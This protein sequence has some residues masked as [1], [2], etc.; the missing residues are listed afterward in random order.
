MKTPHLLLILSATLFAAIALPGIRADDKVKIKDD[1]II[2][3]TPGGKAKIDED[4]NV[5]SAKGPNA[6]EAVSKARQKLS[7][8]E[9]AQYRRDF[10]KGYVIP[11]ERYTYFEPLAATYLERIPERRP[12]VEYRVF[13]GT[14]YA[15]DPSSY[16]II[17]VLGGD[18]LGASA[19]V[20]T[21][22]STTFDPV[23]FKRSLVSGY[24][25]PETYYTH[26]QAVP[27]TIVTRLPAAPA[28]TV[29]RYYD[30]TVYTVNPT[31]RTVI[32]VVA[33]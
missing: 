13:D 4:G 28:G 32:E 29:Y 33:Y 24:V 9:A 3:K 18:I 23:V 10:V 16:R 8:Q 25:I 12:G 15:I 11:R 21:T 19:T 14:V 30:G 27:E 2:V 6:D 26:L 22:R 5:I 17:E 20:T 7:D 31:S 1:K